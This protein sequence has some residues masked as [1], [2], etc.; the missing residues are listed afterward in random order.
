M[1]LEEM[2]NK[3]LVHMQKGKE[4]LTELMK[5]IKEKMR[6]W[7]SITILQWVVCF[8]KYLAIFFV[9]IAVWHFLFNNANPFHTEADSARDMLTALVESHAAIIAIVISLTLIAVQLTASEYSPRV[10]DIFRKNPDMWIL[11]FWYVISIV[12]VLMIL[13]VIEGGKGEVV[14]QSDIWPFNLFSFEWLISIAFLLGVFT[15]FA[16]FLYMWNITNLLK[17]KNVIKQLAI[18]ITSKKILKEED[19][20]Q[21]IEDIIR[22]SIMNHDF[23]TIRVGLSVL[24]DR[25]IQIIDSNNEQIL[26]ERFCKH[27]KRISRLAVVKEVDE[28]SVI[29]VITNLEDCGKA[30]VEKKL[31]NAIGNVASAIGEV[32]KVAVEKGKELENA[33]IQAVFSLEAVGIYAKAKKNE[34]ATSK[35]KSSLEEIKKAA[36]E[37]GEEL[38]KVT[39]QIKSSLKEIE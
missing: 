28:E 22:R 30:T 1:V 7:K 13:R 12:Y 37:K 10:M 4:H 17:L 9:V 31:K 14:S 11:L 3:I 32:G 34:N 35:I 23:E 6:D 18:E 21:P 5:N 39:Q 19:P 29:A 20:I 25:V 26:S 36:M 16:I 27:L 24:T 15:L 38:K 33:T 2:E 8:F